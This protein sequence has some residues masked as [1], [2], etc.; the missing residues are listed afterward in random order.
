MSDHSK[1]PRR[2]FLK[3][4]AAAAGLGV[5]ATSTASADTV[6]V[7]DGDSIQDTVDAADSGD[8]IE[9]GPGTYRETVGL[10]D[11]KALT[12]VGDPGDSSPGPG[13]NAPVLD[14]ELRTETQAFFLGGSGALP[15]TVRGFT[16]KDYGTVPDASWGNG[17]S[18]HDRSN[19][20][21][22]DCLFQNI[23][24]SG[25]RV[26]SDGSFRPAD[27]VIRRNGFVSID[28]SAVHLSANE[29][30]VIANNF[31]ESGPFEVNDSPDRWWEDDTEDH[32]PK[33]GIEIHATGRHGND[34]TLSGVDIVGNYITGTYDDTGIRVLSINKNPIADYPDTRTLAK[35][36]EI[37]DNTVEITDELDDD[38]EG[39][40][41]REIDGDDD[42]QTEGSD[43]M[44]D[45]RDENG[46]VVGANPLAGPP[47]YVEDVRV[48]DNRTSRA[49]SGLIIQSRAPGQVRDVTVRDNVLTNGIRGISLGGSGAE[50]IV[51]SQIANNDLGGNFNGLVL[52]NAT[53][54]DEPDEPGSSHVEV[55][56][57]ENQIVNNKRAGVIAAGDRPVSDTIIHRNDIAENA[58]AGAANFTPGTLSAS[59]NFWGHP[60]GPADDDNRKGQ[61][62]RVVGDVDYEPWIPQS[63]TKVP[64]EACKL[65]N[66]RNE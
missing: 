61:G 46:I 8:T 13:P 38:G 36:I 15:V 39:D 20:T 28:H 48:V 32:N 65:E 42:S 9:V 37:R 41:L 31:V 45:E 40:E 6:T 63:Y 35:D 5:A 66:H 25:I 14:G 43:N 23:G 51:N 4:A 22:E 57:M 29:N 2:S 56:I 60:T 16:I 50:S 59:C 27:W 44:E 34:A 21:V 52:F 47:A 53:H 64:E 33:A 49:A 19:L 26:N 24:G 30:A 1:T 18:V 7:S 54:P 12:L 3:G 10:P 62:N 11:D 17:L 58:I 55:M